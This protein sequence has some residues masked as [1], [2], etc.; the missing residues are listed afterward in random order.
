MSALSRVIAFNFRS[1]FDLFIIIKSQKI[2]THYWNNS[3]NKSSCI[4]CWDLLPSPNLRHS[5]QLWSS[6]RQ[7]RSRDSTAALSDRPTATQPEQHAPEAGYRPTAT[8]PTLHSYWP[9]P[10]TGRQGSRSCHYKGILIIQL[11]M[12]KCLID[13]FLLFALSLRTCKLIIFEGHWSNLL[14]CKTVSSC[15]WWFKD[16]RGRPIVCWLIKIM[17]D[18]SVFL[19]CIHK[20]AKIW[21]ATLSESHL[22]VSYPLH[23]RKHISMYGIVLWVTNN[24]DQPHSQCV[25]KPLPKLY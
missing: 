16:N 4:I 1:Y 14:Q 15:F 17:A 11:M 9:H 5:H 8:Q 12:F 21:R 10:R 20:N 19:N 7:G 24:S 25:T 22:N 3:L 13:I 18:F 2:S 6:G 23:W